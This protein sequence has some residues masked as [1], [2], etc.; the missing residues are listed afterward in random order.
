MKKFI[1]IFTI[2]LLSL[3]FSENCIAEDFEEL[4]IDSESNVESEEISYILEYYNRNKIDLNRTTSDILT[5]L[6]LFDKMV[7]IRII[8]LVQTGVMY[9][10]SDIC[11]SLALSDIQCEI[12]EYCTF[13]NK[14]KEESAPLLFCRVRSRNRLDKTKGFTENKYLGAR[15]DFYQNY[16]F[17]YKNINASILLD[18]DPGELH[19]IDNYSGGIDYSGKQFNL[20][21][22]NYSIASGYGSL[23]AGSMFNRKGSAPV[24]SLIRFAN[25]IRISSSSYPENTLHG[26][27]AGYDML[28]TEKLKLSNSFF[29]SDKELPAN[30]D[31][32]GI[33]TSIYRTGLFRT[34][35]EIGK[36]GKLKERCF[37][38]VSNINSDNFDLTFTYMNI[39]YSKQIESGSKSEFS[40]IRGNLFSLASQY[41]HE[42]FSSGAEFSLDAERNKCI[43]YNIAYTGESWATV[44]YYRYLG[45]NYRAPYSGTINEFSYTASEQGIYWGIRLKSGSKIRINAYTDI[46]KSLGR[47]Y[48]LPLINRG[49]ELMAEIIYKYNP[50]SKFTIRYKNEAK[51]EKENNP[52]I[53]AKQII[54]KSSGLLI[55]QF[56]H[57]INGQWNFRIR[58]D[59]RKV[60]REKLR[61]SE[62]TTA[63]YIELNYLPFQWL[64]IKSRLTAFAGGSYDSAIW[65][66]EYISHGFFATPVLYGNGIRNF[67]SININPVANLDILLRYEITRKNN[68]DA[69]GSGYDEVSGNSLSIITV[70]VDYKL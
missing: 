41:I 70:Q 10:I 9:E 20:V 47:T 3:I 36:I 22:G 27:A 14:G 34:E 69:M 5:E 62:I 13:I 12:L 2:L 33:V 52:E 64:K 16:S 6:P 19:F 55:L 57:Q 40:G 48:N 43:L 66:Y 4:F 61:N 26:I 37:G 35:T 63:S 42:R 15:P 65:Q 45:H 51:P 50:Q 44:L 39:G 56:D 28:L 38:I 58:N 59:I 68:V 8:D 60:S 11:D 25:S 24:S 46:F 21:I 49:S 54:G 17:K 23:T 30:I 67:V 53:N 7:S 1:K 31:T 32:S 18:R 29:Y